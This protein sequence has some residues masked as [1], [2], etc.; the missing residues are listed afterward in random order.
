MNSEERTEVLR[1]ET[2]KTESS[3]VTKTTV[4]SSSES[5]ISTQVMSAAAQQPAESKFL[6]LLNKTINFIKNTRTGTLIY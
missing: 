5:V 2:V 4:I 1:N 3:V 6:F